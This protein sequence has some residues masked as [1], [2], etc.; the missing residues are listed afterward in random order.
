MNRREIVRKF[1]KKNGYKGKY[2]RQILK[3]IA[4]R[5]DLFS[6]ETEKIALYVV[7][8]QKLFND[9]VDSA[10]V[11]GTRKP[12]LK[13]C[14]CIPENFSLPLSEQ[15]RASDYNVDLY[16][17]KN[18][19]VERLSKALNKREEQKMSAEEIKKIL[20]DINRICIVRWGVDLFK[21]NNNLI[22]KLSHQAGNEESFFYQI[23][24]ISSILESANLKEIE[25]LCKPKT[26]RERAFFTNKQSIS[27]I[28]LFLK[29]KIK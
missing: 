9:L 4:F 18:R 28:E 10:G 19:H 29:K 21:I 7:N 3:S 26:N 11:I 6:K 15:K 24:T 1:F 23:S 17:I 13:V 2:S 8:R 16:I 25:F 27:I 12:E 14:L 20:N 22:N 5:F